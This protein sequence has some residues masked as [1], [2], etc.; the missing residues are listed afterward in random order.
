MPSQNTTKKFSK[1]GTRLKHIR[2]S[3]GYKLEKSYILKDGTF[4][5]KMIIC[6]NLSR[7]GNCSMLSKAFKQGCNQNKGTTSITTSSGT[8]IMVMPLTSPCLPLTIT[9]IL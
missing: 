7:G 5:S 9:K 1:F 3:L 6:T 2:F 8:L 4:P